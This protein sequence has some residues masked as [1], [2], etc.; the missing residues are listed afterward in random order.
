MIATAASVH[1]SGVKNK[2][3]HTAAFTEA[4]HGIQAIQALVKNATFPPTAS[5]MPSFNRV[6]AVITTW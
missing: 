6:L 2:T 4:G 5:A 3:P 1:T